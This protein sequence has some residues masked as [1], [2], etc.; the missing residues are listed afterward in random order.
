LKMNLV[1]QGFARWLLPATVT[2]WAL[3]LPAQV[4]AQQEQ[5]I[6]FSAPDSSDANTNVPSLTPRPPVLSDIAGAVRAP[7]FDVSPAPNPNMPS[8]TI[9]SPRGVAQMEQQLDEKENW[10]LMTPE[11]ILGVPTA[12]KILGLSDNNA[13]GLSDRQSAAERFMQ[14]QQDMSTNGMVNFSQWDLPSGESNSADVFGSANPEANSF[15]SQLMGNPAPAQS[16]NRETGNWSFNFGSPAPTV[17]APTPEQIAESEAFQ[18]MIAP[19]STPQLSSTWANE[20]LFNSL[21]SSGLHPAAI[22]QPLQD[23]L[24]LRPQANPMGESYI[25]LNGGVHSPDSVKPLPS[26]IP[27]RLTTPSAPEWKP[28]L[29]P[30]MNP[31]PQPGEIPP[32]QF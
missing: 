23:T 14:R 18:K 10:A 20:N 28:Q 26:L 7:I 2:G 8:L 3:L 19:H 22:P 17:P 1:V 30:W 9:I 21:P 6:L 16:P 11:E 29:P 4:V 13:D 27:E 24:L 32:R 15:F 31:V 12:E 5:S 25:P